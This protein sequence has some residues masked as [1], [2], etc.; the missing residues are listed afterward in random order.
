M[1]EQGSPRSPREWKEE[2]DATAAEQARREAATELPAARG[3][4]QAAIERR[5]NAVEEQREARARAGEIPT[6][7]VMTDYTSEGE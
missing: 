2:Q 3:R 6:E 7:Q 5:D 1:Q 4:L